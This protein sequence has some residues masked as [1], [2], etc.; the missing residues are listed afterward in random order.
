MSIFSGIFQSIIF[1]VFFLANPQF[2]QA[3]E[4]V[5][6][7]IQSY[8]IEPSLFGQQVK[9]EC[10]AVGPRGNL[11]MG[12]RFIESDK[13]LDSG[14]I[15]VYDPSGLLFDSFRLNFVPQGICFTNDKK[16]IVA[17]YGKIAR[18]SLNGAVETEIDAPNL[19][20]SKKT[21][22]DATSLERFQCSG[23]AAT[24]NQ[25]FVACTTLD[26]TGFDVWRMSPNL[27]IEGKVIENLQNGFNHL[28]LYSSG[29]ELMVGP[30]KNLDIGVY[31]FN[32]RPIREIG[33]HS[34]KRDQD[35]DKVRTTN[36]C[37]REDGD[38]L[39]TSTQNGLILRY[40]QSGE[41]I[42]NL[43]TAKLDT[44][45]NFA[46]LGFDLSRNWIYVMNRAKS[47]IAILVLK[48]EA[49]NS[50]EE[51]GQESGTR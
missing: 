5:E 33:K 38:I 32:G 11:W 37:L 24:D 7:H 26:G 21:K 22:G 3:L 18:L 34:E 35:R 27:S 1:L 41:L 19:R 28:D 16:A 47:H 49:P 40:K 30:Q 8:I 12:C 15:L 43:G 14:I 29:I 48:D 13:T 39:T 50:A 20:E 10:F 6:T 4:R 42:G 45:E 25:V 36:I 44:N 17:G 46:S 9:L 23:I 51:V 2:L 31:D